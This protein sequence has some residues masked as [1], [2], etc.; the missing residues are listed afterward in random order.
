MRIPIYRN[1]LILIPL[2]LV[3]TGADAKPAASGSVDLRLD[4]PADP[5]PGTLF[6]M[7]IHRIATTTPWPSVTFGTWRLWDA[8]VAWPN[9][10]PQKDQWD[11]KNLDLYM[12]DAKEHQVEILLPLGLSPQWV[13]SRPEEKS[14]YGPGNAAGPA[15]LD[16]WRDYV[17][18][19]ATRYKGRVFAYEIWNEPN[20]KQFY[21]G[22]IPEMLQ[23]AGAAYTIIKEIDPH[24]VVCSPSATGPDGVAWL[25]Q[26]LQQGGGKYA[27]VIGFHFYTNPDPPENMLPRI[28]R[29]KAVMQKYGLSN[30][31]LWN[32]ETGWAMEN[33]LSV[34]QAAP[35]SVKFNSVVLSEEQASAYVAR[36]HILSWA[37]NVQR[38]YW[39]S[40]DN[41]VMGLT[42]ADGRTV[43]SPARA[44]TVVR[45]WLLGARMNSCQS[46]E[47]GTWACEIT[48]DRDYHGWIVWNPDHS[49]DFH[50]PRSWNVAH[51]RYLLNGETQVSNGKN[52]QIG[53]MPILMEKA[54]Q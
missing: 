42:E 31:T 10:E 41:K 34:V 9:L 20:L 49:T 53:P 1:G 5:V 40:W 36:T 13:S 8:Y 39:Y 27:D 47:T 18:T 15:R 33:R 30:K 26:Y 52:I 28:Q 4:A 7:H 54:I 46:D 14:A 29:V 21:S 17:R 6:G 44:Y 23:L 24:A 19:I 11:F 50:I 12:E 35:A 45:E 43:K 25:D 16:A 37:E 32:T 48:R 22:S 3:L 38:L 51:V 2:L